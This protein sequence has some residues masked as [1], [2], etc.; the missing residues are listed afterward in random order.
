MF[1]E[2]IDVRVSPEQRRRLHEEADRRR[3]S[4]AELVREAI[5]SHLA[6]TPREDRLRALAAVRSM[7]G[8]FVAVDEMEGLIEDERVEG[9]RDKT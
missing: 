1:S 8:R 6:Q 9:L 2:R 7:R 5:L 4:V 3:M